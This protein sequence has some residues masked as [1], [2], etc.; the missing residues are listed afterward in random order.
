MLYKSLGIVL[1]YI[2]YGE[3]SIITRIF[4]DLF[5]KQTYIL[6]GVRSRKP[7]YSMALFQPLMPLDMV[8][9]HKKTA[10]IQRIAE[11][12]CHTPIS[13]ILGDL[14]KATIASF[15]SELL[16]KV[17]YEEEH[18]EALFAFLLHAILQFNEQTVG[19]ETFHLSFMLQLS[20]YLGFGIKS[21]QD[22]DKQLAHAGFHAPLDQNE[23]VWLD[24][25]LIHPMHRE[26]TIKMT[27]PI[28]RKLTTHILHY[29]QIHIDHLDMPKSLKILQELAS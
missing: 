14:K 4:T 8:I 23:M 9:Y 16:G 13:N 3:T 28:L 10:H 21:A 15:L 22:V 26:E 18:N 19:Y 20:H 11:V 27:K 6:H 1:N 17:L 25:L 2:K 7:K 12:R 24:D 5:G 29:Y